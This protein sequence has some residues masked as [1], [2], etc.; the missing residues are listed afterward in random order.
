MPRPTPT[1]V[2]EVILQVVQ[3]QIPKGPTDASLQQRTVLQEVKKRLQ[4][5]HGREAQQTVLTEWRELFR[6][7]YFAWGLDFP[8]PDPP[9]FHLTERSRRA[10]EQFSRDPGNPA[11]YLK[12]LSSVGNLNPVARSYLTEA[13][14]CYDNDLHKAAAVMIGCA[15]ESVILELRD[16]VLDQLKTLNQPV[17]KKL[18]DWKVKTVLD[19]LQ[20]FLDGKKG[21]FSKD[22]REGY[23]AYWAAFA[24]QIRAIRN[25]AGHPTSIDPVTPDAVHASFLIF[26]ELARLSASL[27]EWITKKLK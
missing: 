8:N 1:E 22:L 13:L 4:I 24:Q 5:G 21:L 6:T 11:G 3:D 19:E 12:H 14:D 27:I 25:D 16:V 17:P 15:A 9:F 26:P 10:F 7:G 23:E 2:R 20:H 18:S